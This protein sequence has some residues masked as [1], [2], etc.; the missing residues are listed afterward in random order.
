MK[1]YVLL[2]Q[3]TRIDTT[4][5]GVFHEPTAAIGAAR[6]GAHQHCVTQECYEE[7]V[8]RGREIFRATYGIEGECFRVETADPPAP[9]LLEGM[10]SAPPEGVE[11]SRDWLLG[12]L[13][14]LLENDW[15]IVE[16]VGERDH[17]V[18]AN[19]G[20]PFL[21][22]FPG[23]NLYYTIHLRL[24]KAAQALLDLGMDGFERVRKSLEEDDG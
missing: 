1:H 19:P 7:K 22:R 24:S 8:S 6:T 12:I 10:P 21:G 13:A 2:H 5:C 4:S 3:L 18:K 11:R 9:V 17:V 15:E 14:G 16:V 23:P 20:S